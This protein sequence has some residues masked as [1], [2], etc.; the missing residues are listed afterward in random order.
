LRPPSFRTTVSTVLCTAVH[1][2]VTKELRLTVGSRS[3]QANSLESH[4]NR[5]K[6]SQKKG[7]ISV[8]FGQ[9]RP[10]YKHGR[11][12]GGTPLNKRLPTL[13]KELLGPK[14][15]VEKM[16]TRSL[17]QSIH[18]SQQR[19]HQTSVAF[20]KSNILNLDLTPIFMLRFSRPT[21]LRRS[22]T[23]QTAPSDDKYLITY[24]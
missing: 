7:L 16:E 9:K 2:C 3:G 20:E 12:I 1:G 18:R 5:G 23:L 6:N 24:A 14:R 8:F 17:S 19:P 15:H 13:E 21:R 22:V 11:K 4:G 10:V